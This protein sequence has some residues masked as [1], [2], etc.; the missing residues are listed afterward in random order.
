VRT[1]AKPIARDAE[2]LEAIEEEVK[3]RAWIAIRSAGI[4]MRSVE[5]TETIEKRAAWSARSLNPAAGSPAIWS[6]VAVRLVIWSLVA[7]GRAGNRKLDVRMKSAASGKR[8]N[9]ASI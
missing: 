4:T 2:T 7:R 6:L 5:T 8:K 1:G 9:R 3:R